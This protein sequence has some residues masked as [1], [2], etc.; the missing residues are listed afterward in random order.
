MGQA[1][2]CLPATFVIRHF[3]LQAT[4]GGEMLPQGDQEETAMAFTCSLCHDNPRTN[5][6]MGR[7]ASHLLLAQR[8]L[9]L[10]PRE[11][12]LSLS[13]EETGAKG[14]ETRFRK[15]VLLGSGWREMLFPVYLLHF[16][17]CLYYLFKNKI[18]LT[19]RKKFHFLHMC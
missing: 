4:P 17:R 12:G 9:H 3:L 13:R 16:T 14:T 11:L 15:H 7:R 10:Q 6:M 19:S 8:P 1:S 18:I 2:D 5:G